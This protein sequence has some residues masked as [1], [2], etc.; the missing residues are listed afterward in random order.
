MTNHYELPDV[1]ELGAA[2]E[3]ILGQKAPA[4]VA[5]SLSVPFTREPDDIN[6]FDE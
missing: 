1:I 4:A 2:H 3:L 5:D 6:D